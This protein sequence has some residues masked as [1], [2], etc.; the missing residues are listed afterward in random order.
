MDD[1]LFRGNLAAIDP[2]VADLIN[3]EAE[4]QARHLILIPS[5]STI[6]WAV[7]EALTSAFHNIYAE[8]YPPEETRTMTEAELLDF[9]THLADYRRY[10]D[11]RY[12]KGTEYANLIEALAR[13]RCAEL[14]A[15]DKFGP[16]KLFVN[17]QPLSGAPVNSAVYTALIQPGDTIMGLDLLHGGHLSH[18]SPAARSGKQY[19]AVYYSVNPH[20]DR[21]DYEEIHDVALEYKPKVIIG[22]YTSY[23]WAPDWLA[24]RRIA[25]EVGAYLLADVSHVSGLIIAG[26]YPNPV[27]IADVVTFTTHKTLGGPRGAVL[28]THKADLAR[29]LDRG[30]FPG[31]QGGPHM[32]T[33]AALAVAFKLA[34]TPQFHELQKQTVRNAE[35]LAEQLARHGLRIPHNGTNTHLLLVDT[36]SVTG[37][38]GTPLSG[39]MAARILDLVGITCN[40]NTI[41]GDKTAARPT[42]IRLGTPWITQRGFREPEIDRLAEIIAT[43]LKACKPFSY[44]GKGGKADWRAKIDFPTY[45]QTQ[46]AVAELCDQAGLDYTLPVV[47][48][49]LPHAGRG[50]L[51]IWSNS[52][53]SVQSR[54]IT[55]RGDKARSFLSVA[56]TSDVDALTDGKS[57]PTLILQTD[58]SVLS[59]GII[60][61]ERADSFTLHVAQQG[62]QSAAWLRALSDGFVI[63]D[64]HDLYGKLPGPVVINL[65]ADP[66]T[67]EVAQTLSKLNP[68]ER[69]YDLNKPYFVGCRGE[70]FAGP[71]CAPLPAFHWQEPA[72]VPLKR[73]A[74]Y[75]LHREL[76]AKMTPFAGYDM[77]VWY[78]SVSEEHKAVRQGAGVFDVTHMGVWEV[79]GTASEDFLNALTTND[80]NTLAPGESQYSYLLDLDGVPLDDIF[81][82][83]LAHDHFMTVVNASNNDKDWAWA[84]AIRNG[85]VLSAPNRPGTTV[86]SY[87]HHVELRDLRDPAAGDDGRVDV[88]LQGPKSRDVLL[89]L[90]GSDA[91]K[92]QIKALSWG[93]VT[94]ATLGGFD[95]IVSRT[96]YTGE[97]TAF[98]L[99]VRPDR[100][101]ELIRALLAHGATPCGLASRDSTRIE[102]GLPLYGH[103]LGGE[104]QFTPGDAGFAS[105]VKL[106]KPFF[107][108]KWAY[109]ERELA[110]ASVVTRFRM[111]TKGVKPPQAGDPVLDKRGRVIGL[112]T[113]CSI[114]TEG[115]QLG[116]AYL[117]EDVAEEG[118]PV[119][120]FSGAARSKDGKP[121][122]D[123]RPGDK[124]TIPEAATVQSR[125][126]KKKA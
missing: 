63:Y 24:L 57:Q 59:P 82:Y 28:I 94:R 119:L 9:D 54:T 102:A 85:T 61:R 123:L 27:G 51:A 81:V 29:K 19:H 42:G 71:V 108:G 16:N 44:D 105:Y 32:N 31:E 36:K 77:P 66:V 91:D 49:S 30:V 55:I 48:D 4:R 50:H 56:L 26:V 97:R 21:L 62:S 104:H 118:T 35:R 11:P 116:Q 10:G 41:P 25:E 126:P 69:Y 99:F 93:G 121:P 18:G 34:K 83:R 124:A 90:D 73:T 100:A 110:R 15:T 101:P 92:A 38:D 103:E 45:L 5:E 60:V 47:G 3:L 33:I 106:W 23:P 1:F 70:H 2:D 65:L 13:R 107:I 98:E 37:T 109:I 95:L 120:I 8:G 111:D 125:F 52:D 114:D 96:G 58:G 72:D 78:T 84:N 79:R 53:E 86:L 17:V 39:D 89:S 87:A 46:Q 12:Y 20:T 7:R 22:G 75:D 80:V 14:F 68:E 40:R 43:V 64:S 112:V 6:P 117:K 74:S 115:Y 76:G 67:G 122:A 88:A 113:S